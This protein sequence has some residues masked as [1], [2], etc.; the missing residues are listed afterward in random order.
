MSID[1]TIDFFHAQ[2]DVVGCKCELNHGD[3]GAK[4]DREAVDYLCQEFSSEFE[5]FSIRIPICEECVHALYGQ[6]WVLLF[7]LECC[8]SQWIYKRLA[9]RKYE[10]GKNVIWMSACPNCFKPTT[11]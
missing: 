7:C 6:D 1:N 3:A 2:I 10:D 4:E 5:N 11:T 8:S 9:K